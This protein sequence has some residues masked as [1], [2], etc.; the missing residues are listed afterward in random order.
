[1]IVVFACAA[2]AGVLYK[3]GL[4]TALAELSRLQ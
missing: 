2:V 4:V 3:T 1:M